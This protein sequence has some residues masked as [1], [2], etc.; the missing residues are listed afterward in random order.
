MVVSTERL[1]YE[2]ESTEFLPEILEKV[3]YN[4]VS[5]ARNI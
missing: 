1:Y 2:A 3:I 5:K 4:F